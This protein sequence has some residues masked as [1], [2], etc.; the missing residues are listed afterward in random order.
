MSGRMPISSKVVLT[1]LRSWAP[2]LNAISSASALLR[3]VR[4]WFAARQQIATPFQS[5]K[6]P[7]I[8]LVP[9]GECDASVYNT[10]LAS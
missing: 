9:A 10:S 6:D 3:A 5:T 8:D 7:E 4:L 1:D 2:S